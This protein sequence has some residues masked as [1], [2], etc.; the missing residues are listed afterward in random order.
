MSLSFIK[1]YI[2]EGGHLYMCLVLLATFCS[3]C[4]SN[5]CSLILTT[6]GKCLKLSTDYFIF[7]YYQLRLSLLLDSE[8]TFLYCLI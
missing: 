2:V 7:K 8:I 1:A 6:F 3:Q 5:P 4:N